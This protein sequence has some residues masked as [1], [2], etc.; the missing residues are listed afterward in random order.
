MHNLAIR[1]LLLS[2]ICFIRYESLFDTI[3]A[4]GSAGSWVIVHPEQDIHIGCRAA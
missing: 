4:L 1:G 3:F 2:N